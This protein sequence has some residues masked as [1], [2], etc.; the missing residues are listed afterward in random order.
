MKLVRFTLPPDYT[1]RLADCLTQNDIDFLQLDFSRCLEQTEHSASKFSGDFRSYWRDIHKA[2]Y[3]SPSLQVVTNAGG[4]QVVALME[5][6]AEFLA[7]HGS[8][9]LPIAA[10]RGS[11]LINSLE[12]FVP[13]EILSKDQ[14]VLAAQVEIG[15]GPIAT[16]LAE[17]ARIVVCGDYDATAPFLAA[18][19][20]EGFCTWEG[21]GQLGQLA[22][23]SQFPEMLVETF[24]DG[25]VKI[26]SGA[27]GHLD[28]VQKLGRVRHADLACDYSQL[29]LTPSRA[30]MTISNVQVEPQ[31]YMWN[32]RLTFERGYQLEGVIST[33]GDHH[34]QLSRFCEQE[35]SPE[36]FTLKTFIFNDGTEP[37]EYLEKLSYQ[38]ATLAE[39]QQ[40]L[41]AIEFFLSGN[42]WGAIVEPRPTIEMIQI[43]EWH[44]IPRDELTLAVETRPAREW[45]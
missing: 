11:N 43:T 9:N 23:A 13:E 45:L 1:T 29:E 7:E 12:Q 42:G 25:T 3:L 5:A 44:L 33:E 22:A 19:V 4:D 26:E 17:G 36:K 24:S 6:L 10:I 28:V 20:S 15:A 31:S 2:L 35:M 30:S 32:L 39:C 21:I 18:G 16:A 41:S 8:A 38:G 40:V 34:A 14:N 27:S 37:Y